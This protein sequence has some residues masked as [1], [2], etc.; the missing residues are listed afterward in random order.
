MLKHAENTMAVEPKTLDFSPRSEF[1]VG[2][3]IVS[4]FDRL[5]PALQHHIVNTLGWQ[6]LRP[7]QEQAIA[8]LLAGEHALLLAPT[9]GGKTE[10]AF[11][12]LLSR[13]VSEDW[14]GTSLLYVSPLKALLNNLEDRLRQYCSMVGRRVEL[15]HGDVS[16][17][18]RR[19]IVGERPDC[20]LITPES[21]E[22]ILV[23]RRSDKERAF[24]SVQVVIVDEIHAFAGDDRG[25]HLLAV[26]ERID[27]LARREMQRV[28]LSAT[29]GNPDS[30]LDWLA[31]RCKAPIEVRIIYLQREQSERL[32][33]VE[34]V[35][36]ATVTILSGP[37]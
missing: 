17:G 13:M 6:A 30:L 8:P 15:W 11:F 7:L 37:Q 14:Q 31:G 4:A 24:G 32:R 33:A 19:R 34:S 1:L 23:S 16:E 28:G 35:R 27:R 22:V 20:L 18:R 29:V 3:A 26:L 21:L 10:A 25:W 9:A 2:T 12:P 36:S 5:H